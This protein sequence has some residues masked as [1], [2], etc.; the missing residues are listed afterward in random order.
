MLRSISYWSR[1]PELSGNAEGGRRAISRWLRQ[2]N[3]ASLKEASD[4][5]EAIPIVRD[6]DQ[7]AVQRLFILDMIITDETLGGLLVNTLMPDYFPPHSLAT[8]AVCVPHLVLL[9]TSAP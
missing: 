2:C 6:V 1:S 3:V 5:I 4:P 8:H 9:E 7:R